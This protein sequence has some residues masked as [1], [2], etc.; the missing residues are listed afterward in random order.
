[1]SIFCLCA[2]SV[3][4]A[5]WQ[6]SLTKDPPGQFPELRSLRAKYNFGW[7]GFTAAVGDVH[8]AKVAEDRFQFEGNGHTTGLARALWKF[9]VDHRS[10]ADANTLRPVETTQTETAGKK[11][12][13]THLVFSNA[14]VARSRSDNPGRPNPNKPKQFNLPSLFDLQS[15]MLYLR[16]QPL[17]DHSTYR[18]VVYPTTAAYLATITVSGR[19]KISVHA[20]NY[21][22]IQLDLRLNKV[23]KNLELEP[24]KKFKQATLWVSDD[25][26]RLIIRAEAQ[27]FVGS[28][29][30]ELQSLQFDPAKR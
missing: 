23:G 4:A 20:G 8:F 16:S 22:A 12:Q 11:K 14:G 5:D 9:D 17:K 7:S 15:A 6:A 19:E 24:H 1:M 28:V 18:I 26:D 13:L 21:N 2:G 10:L 30:A 25:N 29:F 3:A 27:I